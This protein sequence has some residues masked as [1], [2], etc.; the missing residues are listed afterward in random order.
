MKTPRQRK[1]RSDRMKDLMM[2]ALPASL[3]IKGFV[4]GAADCNYERYMLEFVNA[5]GFFRSK[6]AG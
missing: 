5:S 3:V 1:G 4:S 6:S 2:R